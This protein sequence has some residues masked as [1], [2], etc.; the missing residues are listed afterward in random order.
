MIKDEMKIFERFINDDIY[1]N[2]I[3]YEFTMKSGDVFI[4]KYDGEGESEINPIT[5]ED[6]YYYG[7]VFYIIK[8][9]KDLSDNYCDGA[10]IEIS[11]YDFP[12]EI[13]KI[14]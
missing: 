11:K 6:D 4:V 8:V 2:D 12:V 1:H 3:T 14:V 13:K 9:L 7:F 5:G 10:L